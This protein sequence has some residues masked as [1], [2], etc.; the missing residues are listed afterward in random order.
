MIL[1][2]VLMSY[3]T[4]SD[5]FLLRT[6]S[7]FGSLQN[8]F[9]VAA[10][11]VEFFYTLSAY[12]FKAVDI[13][14]FIFFIC[15]IYHWAYVMSFGI[16]KWFFLLLCLLQYLFCTSFTSV[17]WYCKRYVPCAL[18]QTTDWTFGVAPLNCN[19]E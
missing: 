19:F 17:H 18:C 8:Y 10:F 1:F 2:I 9:F 12:L 5:I 3:Y 14:M 13:S 4:K 15:S 6:K 7:L 16:Y 11:V